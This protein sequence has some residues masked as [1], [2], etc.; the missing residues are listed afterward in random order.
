MDDNHCS[1]QYDSIY[2]SLFSWRSLICC[3]TTSVIDASTHQLL[4]LFAWIS[5]VCNWFMLGNAWVWVNN[6]LKAS[7]KILQNKQIYAIISL[8]LAEPYTLYYNSFLESVLFACIFFFFCLWLNKRFMTNQSN[9]AAH[10]LQNIFSKWVLIMLLGGGFN[11]KLI[12][13]D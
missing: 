1:N 10:C 11:Y 13:L 3:I 12:L 5:L 8:K 6:F 4:F 2:L 9:K 7:S